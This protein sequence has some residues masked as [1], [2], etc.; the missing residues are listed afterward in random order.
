MRYL[1]ISTSFGKEI[2]PSKVIVNKGP[3]TSVK[4][5]FNEWYIQQTVIPYERLTQFQDGPQIV[6]QLARHLESAGFPVA[7]DPDCQWYETVVRLA[8]HKRA[9]HRYKPSYTPAQ[10]LKLLQVVNRALVDLDGHSVMTPM[11]N[12]YLLDI[13]ALMSAAEKPVNTKY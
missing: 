1:L 8:E 13:A 5:W 11:L 4:Y 12:Q 10:T 7:S 2:I 9:P 3:K 6:Q